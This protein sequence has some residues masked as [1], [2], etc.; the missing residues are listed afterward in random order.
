MP[1]AILAR[2]L[3]VRPLDPFPAVFSGSGA[4]LLLAGS[5][6]A[7]GMVEALLRRGDGV[8]GAVAG[9]AEAQGWAARRGAAV[10]H[11]LATSLQL[12]CEP[13]PPWAG[14][15]LDQPRLMGVLN[16]T[17]DSFSDGGA[18]LDPGRAIAHGEAMLAAGADFID[19]GGESTRPGA[20]AVPAE[21]Q[22][23]RVKPVIEGLARQGAL[24]SIDTR[25][26][27]VM[28]AALDAGAR[29]VNDVSALTADPEALALVAR[30]GAAL[31]LMHMQGEPGSMQAAPHYSLASLDIV[32]YLAARLALCEA[33]GIRRADILVD[34]GLG[35]GKTPA[36][37]LEILARLGLLHGLG[38]G[39]LLGVSRKSLVA[40]LSRGE[41]PDQRLPGSLAAAFHGLQRGVQVLRVHDVAE[42]RQAIAMWSAVLSAR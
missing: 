15:T 10:E 25:S 16:V 26:A 21:E 40:R 28:G 20:A 3:W 12:L 8:E 27:A 18:F 37:N 4:T 13:R 39:I 33:A 24:V 1:S 7:F 17:P 42:T 6:L 34:P 14:L 29:I 30:R 36:H 38:C 11:R 31:V 22:I 41:P 32:E 5:R 23:R 35:F 9:L 2:D 19:V